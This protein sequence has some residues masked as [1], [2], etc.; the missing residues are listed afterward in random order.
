MSGTI[1]V[2]LTFVFTVLI[3]LIFLT[4]LPNEKL[5]NWGFK[6]GSKWSKWMNKKLGRLN[7]EGIE[8]NI[9]GSVISFAQGIKDGADSD[10]SP[11]TT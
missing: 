3:P 9:T 8:N 10:D 11:P 6:Y 7:W 5:Y 2:I 4:F 1:G